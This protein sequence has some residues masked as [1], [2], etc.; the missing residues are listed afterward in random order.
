MADLGKA[1]LAHI[2]SKKLFAVGGIGLAGGNGFEIMGIESVRIFVYG[3]DR[4]VYRLTA[5]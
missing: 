1:V 2:A 4:F 5:D 3:N